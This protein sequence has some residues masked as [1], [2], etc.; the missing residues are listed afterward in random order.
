MVSTTARGRA[1]GLVA[2]AARG[3]LGRRLARAMAA[4]GVGG[5]EVA[6]S[7]VDDD[8]I[9]ALN[10]RYRRKDRPTDVLSFSLVEGAAGLATPATVERGL[11]G[12]VVISVE[13]AA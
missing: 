10:R 2:R 11:L 12:D 3:R 5:A 4:A 7:L 1:T 8:E 13:T 9:R 6:L